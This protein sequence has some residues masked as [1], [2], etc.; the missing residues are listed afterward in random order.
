MNEARV[1]HTII[2]KM[3][4]N[5]IASV[6]VHLPSIAT[7]APIGPSIHIKNAEKAPKNAM[8]E[9][10]PGTYIATRVANIE[11]RVRSTMVRIRRDAWE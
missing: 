2:T 9:P 4:Q 1:P 7:L 6:A 5:R 11:T 8:R 10:N 3:M